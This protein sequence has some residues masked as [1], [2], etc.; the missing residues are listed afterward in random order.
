MTI[1]ARVRFVTLE[2]VFVNMSTTALLGSF[3][4][5]DWSL[6]ISLLVSV[7]VAIALVAINTMQ[8]DDLGDRDEM[9]PRH[10]LDSSGDDDESASAHRSPL[11][12]A[13]DEVQVALWMIPLML[14]A[15]AISC[16]TQILILVVM[17]LAF[18]D[19]VTAIDFLLCLAG[20]IV[21]SFV[22]DFVIVENL[23]RLLGV[24]DLVTQ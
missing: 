9:E 19:G 22:Y 1:A 14:V 10:E 3:I 6:P 7:G 15:A 17:A 4:L 18:G 5:T 20:S 23:A 16:R 11:R 13:W 24:H 21:F 8:S 12:R 2:A